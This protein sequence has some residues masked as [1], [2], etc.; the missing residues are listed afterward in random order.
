MTM[1]AQL[2]NPPRIM[3]GL[4]RSKHLVKWVYLDRY[5]TH[6]LNKEEAIR[7]FQ[8]FGFVNIDESK[9]VHGRVTRPVP[10]SIDFEK[11]P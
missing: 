2:S 6:A 4:T 7:I 10:V 5:E 11:K 3:T 9:L 8:Q 1:A